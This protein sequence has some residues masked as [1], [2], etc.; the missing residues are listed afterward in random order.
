M[1]LA[2]PRAPHIADY[3]PE[4]MRKPVFPAVSDDLLE[5]RDQ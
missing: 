2:L 3:E 4:P 5:L 1:P